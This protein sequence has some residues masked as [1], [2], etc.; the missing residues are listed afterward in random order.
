MEARSALAQ[1]S[2]GIDVESALETLLAQSKGG[3]EFDDDQVMRERQRREEEDAERRRRRR[4]GPSRASVQPRT[5]EQIRSTTPGEY[6]DQAEKIMAQAT[7][8][9]TTFL[10]GATSFWNSSKEKALKVYEEQKKAR[11]AETRKDIKDGRPRWMVDAEREDE[12]GGS[13]GP[14]GGFK[15]SDEETSTNALGPKRETRPKQVEGSIQRPLEADLLGGDGPKT[16]QPASRRPRPAAPASP[17]TPVRPPT[18]LIKRILVDASSTQLQSSAS[19]KAKGNEH[20][21]LGRFSEAES[22]Y[23]SAISA[24]PEGHL[25][26]IPLHNNRAATRLKLGESASAVKDCSVVISIV[27]TSYHPSKEAPLPEEMGKEVKLGDALVKATTK[28]AQAWEMGEK[29]S[30]ALED[31]ERVLGFDATLVGADA[32]NTKTLASEGVRRAKKM[33]SGDVSANGNAVPKVAPSRPKPAPRK[34]AVVSKSVAVSELRKAN[35]AAEA[36]DAQRTAV[37][38]SVDAKVAAWK[39]GKETNLRALIASLDTVLWDDV[40]SG[41]LRVGM[42]ELITEKQVKIKYMKVIARLHPDKVRS[43]VAV[44]TY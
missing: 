25:Y 36:E 16:Y 11:E 24:L 33:L 34:P 19:K 2:T 37:K 5:Q 42:H 17:P 41:G 29:W 4:A 27:G 20:F 43:V 32:G 21:K 26:L 12:E 35:Q 7:E 15:D 22:A 3:D 40:L 28:R 13:E 30:K 44:R 1:T 39:G 23:T 14:A 9:G 8:I 31:W 10:K 18:P 6:G 38:D